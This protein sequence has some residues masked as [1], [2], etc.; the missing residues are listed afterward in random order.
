MKRGE[1]DIAYSVRGEL[2]SELEQTPGLGL[3][4]VVVQGTF[5][6]YFPEQRKVQVSFYL[7]D[8][9]AADQPGKTKIV[10]SDY[11]EFSLGEPAAK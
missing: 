8:E 11:L 1:I 5:A 10:R 9:P 2:A 7:R 4:A 6:L 3:K